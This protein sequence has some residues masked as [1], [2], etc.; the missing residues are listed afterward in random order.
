MGIIYF[1]NYFLILNVVLKG[2][3]TDNELLWL[4]CWGMSI[5][6][7]KFSKQ[8]YSLIKP[9]AFMWQS[10]AI[11]KRNPINSHSIRNRSVVFLLAAPLF[12][13][14]NQDMKFSPALFVRGKISLRITESLSW[15]L[16]KRRMEQTGRL[17]QWWHWR[18]AFFCSVGNRWYALL[19][20]GRTER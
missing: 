6:R 3:V 9:D 15:R 8:S 14:D 1:N 20:D 2:V 12:P 5:M 19:N 18:K 17:W 7:K 10:I 4:S 16:S 11:E 13:C